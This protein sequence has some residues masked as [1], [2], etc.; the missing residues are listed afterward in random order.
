MFLKGEEISWDNGLQTKLR[1]ALGLSNPNCHFGVTKKNHFLFEPISVV[2]YTNAF[3]ESSN[4]IH[5]IDV[6]FC[7]VCQDKLL[8]ILGL[9]VLEK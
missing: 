4:Y 2:R 7:P 9:C 6:I 3:V 1:R 5:N 8:L